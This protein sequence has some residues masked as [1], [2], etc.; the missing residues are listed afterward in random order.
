MNER[1]VPPL[2]GLVLAGGFSR[3][4][5]REKWALTY[6]GERQIERAIALLRPLVAEVRVSCRPEQ[7]AELAPLG[8]TLVEDAVDAE[9]P[10][11]GIA[12]ALLAEPGRAWLV[13]ACDLPLLDAA[14]LRSLVEG[15]D[16]QRP[17]TACVGPAGAPEPLCA[18]YEPAIRSALLSAI[19]AGRHSPLRVLTEAGAALV[20]PADLEPLTNVNEP[21]E[22]DAARRR[23]LDT[24]E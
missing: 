2:S 8:A 12:S 23:L 20:E 6:G 14:T 21:H 4:M 22:Y 24:G 18:I 19:R 3:R 17:A 13:L 1:K 11:A 15:R 9:G 16:P 7:R 10:I 5:G